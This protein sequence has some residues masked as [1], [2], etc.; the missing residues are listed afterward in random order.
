MLISTHDNNKR[1]AKNTILLYFRLM[2]SMVV[3]L[4]TSRIILQALGVDDF[5]L[6]VVVTSV[7]AVFY[8]VSHTMTL[9]TSRFLSYELGINVRKRIQKTFSATLTIHILIA[10]IVLILGETVGLWYLENKMVVPEG[11]MTAARWVYQLSLISAMI[12][13]I[14]VPYNAAIVAHEKMSVYAA[15]EILKACL[16]LLI[17]YLLKVGDF[18]KLIFYAILTLCT[19]V[20]IILV[21]RLYCIKNFEECRYR[22]E[23]DKSIIYPILSLSGW[24]LFGCAGLVSKDKGVNLILN[25]FFSVAIN[26]AYGLASQVSMAVNSFASNFFIALKPQMVKY[27]AENRI[28]DMENL[29]INAT[30]YSVLMLS[31]LSLPLILEMDFILNTWLVF[32]PA[33]TGI[34]SRLFLVIVLINTFCSSINYVVY[35]IGKIRIQSIVLGSVNM[36]VPIIT[37]FIFKAGYKNLYMPLLLSIAASIITFFFVLINTHCLIPQISIYK[38]LKK[39]VVVCLIIIFISSVC[40]LFLHFS[41]EKGWL[42]LFVVAISSILMTALLTYYIALDKQARKKIS[43]IVAKKVKCKTL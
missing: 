24:N 11:R 42:R 1:L 29:T 7:V 41:L 27:Y 39:A 23:I 8:L 26:S 9:S 34:F 3:S 37:Y 19:S 15:I 32:V 21:Y 10:I 20:F 16:L 14:Q 28:S 43:V 12:A 18:D 40:P 22:F 5:G 38:F 4:Y 6:N 36:L 2:F 33:Y 31:A 35:A 30:K 17:A 25:S 13:I